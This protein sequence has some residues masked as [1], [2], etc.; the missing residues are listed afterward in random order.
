MRPS[1][2]QL[3]AI[4]ATVTRYTRDGD[5]VADREDMAPPQGDQDSVVRVAHDVD[6]AWIQLAQLRRREVRQLHARGWLGGGLAAGPGL[7]DEAQ[8]VVSNE[9]PAGDRQI[10]LDHPAE[11]P[12]VVA[13]G[14]GHEMPLDEVPLRLDRTAGVTVA[15]GV[16][17]G[18]VD[19]DI[20]PDVAVTRARGGCLAIVRAEAIMAG[21][22]P[23][24]LRVKKTILVPDAPLGIEEQLQLPSV[25][26][27]IELPPALRTVQLQVHDLAR[28]HRIREHLDG[29][30][31]ERVHLEPALRLRARLQ[32]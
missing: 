13:V 23:H 10:E 27:A 2:D 16:H 8:A 12:L 6:A 29:I 14:A 25:H 17:A 20:L 1:S 22:G 3:R 31:R 5:V 9:A 15:H 32:A 19:L 26:L 21:K 11:V 7:V 24:I 18:E 28:H 4:G 30:R